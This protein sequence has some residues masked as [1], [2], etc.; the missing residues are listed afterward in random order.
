MTDKE[1]EHH[2]ENKNNYNKSKFELITKKFITQKLKLNTMK[3][4]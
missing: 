2:R 1:K 3:C 4:Y